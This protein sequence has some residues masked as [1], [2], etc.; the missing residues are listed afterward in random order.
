MLHN[1][2]S[3]PGP[4]LPMSHG[5][6]EIY[7]RRYTELPGKRR[8]IY[9]RPIASETEAATA[10][11]TP[12]TRE[13]A[14]EVWRDEDFYLDPTVIDLTARTN[15]PVVGRDVTEVVGAGTSVLM[16]TTGE[17]VDPRWF[18]EHH[19]WGHEG[20]ESMPV[21]T[22][23]FHFYSSSYTGLTAIQNSV[24]VNAGLRTGRPLLD[25]GRSQLLPLLH[26]PS[27]P[28]S[29]E[30]THAPERYFLIADLAESGGIAYLD[31]VM[32]SEGA[33]GGTYILCLVYCSIAYP[34]RSACRGDVRAV[35]SDE[36][37]LGDGG[38]GYRGLGSI[39][40]LSSFFSQWKRGYRY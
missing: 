14:S 3:L 34:H 37:I 36:R 38:M 33:A 23:T 18:E 20:A 13:N 4:T 29:E 35:F 26:Q 1:T 21:L 39:R 10:E 7:A 15:Q 6:V 32:G 30:F 2:S 5:V 28:F 8:V 27:P 19:E 16:E 11:S 40:N 9:E 17:S 12:T 24:H 22:P 25:S 31:G